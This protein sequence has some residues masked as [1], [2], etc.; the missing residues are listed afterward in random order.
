M[1]LQIIPLPWWNLLH[2][3][4][5]VTHVVFLYKCFKRL[6][7]KTQCKKTNQTAN[8]MLVLAETTV[9]IIIDIVPLKKDIYRVLHS[10]HIKANN[11]IISKSLKQQRQRC[12]RL[13]K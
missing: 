4:L 9:E 8:W 3:L 7:L 6:S 12:Q 13:N 5:S 2:G 1:S 11:F 10:K